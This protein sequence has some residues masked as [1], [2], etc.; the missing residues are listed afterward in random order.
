MLAVPDPDYGLELTQNSKVGWAFSLSRQ[1]SCINATEVCLRCCYGNGITYASAAQRH[2]RLRN[3]RTCKFLL[4]R[5]GPELL[6]QNLIAL[7]DQARPVDWLSA[8]ISGIQTSL[9]WT[10]RLQDVG[11]FFSREYAEAWLIT[12]QNR[13]KCRFWF[14]TRSFLDPALL[15]VLSLMAK[16]PNCQGLLSIDSDNFEQGL[17]AFAAYP[18]VWKLA[19]LQQAEDELDLDLLPAIK[20]QVKL[21]EIVNFPYHRSGR[22]AIPVKAEPL[23]QCPQ[24]TT[25]AFPLETNRSKIK[26]CQACAICLP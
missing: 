17:K 21:G 16:E 9:P 19:L 5:G 24:I 14:Y 26:P 4:K 23:T 2:K 6:A 13:P 25:S 8:E 15:E 10:L 3:F 20:E 1:E 12:I 18:G 11:D 22:H 7:V